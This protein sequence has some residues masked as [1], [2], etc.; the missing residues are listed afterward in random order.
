LIKL[1]IENMVARYK[2]SV[3]Y[4]DIGVPLSAEGESRE[5]ERPA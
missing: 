4:R 3:Y 5:G 2:G 1:V